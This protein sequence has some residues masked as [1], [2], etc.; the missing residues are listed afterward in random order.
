MSDLR[1]D[2]ILN[3]WV[4]VAAGRSQRPGA[5]IESPPFDPRLPCPFCEGHEDE[6]PHEVLA[7]RDVA[8]E[9]DRPRWRVRV[10][11]NKF[12][13]IESGGARPVD[14]DFYRRLDGCGA[15]EVIIESPRH[16]ASTSD[17]SSAELTE[18]FLAWQMRLAFWKRDSRMAYGQLFKNVGQAA[19]ASLE[20]AHSQLLVIPRVPN[21]VAAEI[22][23][24]LD[25][26]QRRGS[27]PFCDMIRAELALGQRIV[28]ETPQHLSFVPFAARLPFETW[29][30]PKLH[31]GHYEEIPRPHLE[32]LAA[33]VRSVIRRLEAA[34]GRCAYNY[35]LHTTP[36]A[37]TAAANYHWHLE[38]VPA[39]VKTAG[40]EL[41]SGW[42]INP[43]A[44]ED[45][46]RM[47]REQA[48]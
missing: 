13:A 19:G 47:M 5:F 6:T 44:P 43:V 4:I 3:H 41:A 10:V 14:G 42:F 45:S 15:H 29:I 40:F 30:L 37:A 20:H 25:Y 17:L 46:A 22:A 48:D 7:F 27:C 11:P 35:V 1:Q 8:G 32:D 34:V 2:P 18:V 33:I 36:F 9:T 39:M 31:A 26:F 23:A 38:I 24:A 12:P 28:A 21:V 16:L